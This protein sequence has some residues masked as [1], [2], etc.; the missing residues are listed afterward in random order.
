[1][2][3]RTGPGR[4]KHHTPAS[5]RWTTCCLPQGDSG[6]ELSDFSDAGQIDSC[7]KEALTLLVK[8][9]TVGGNAGKL[10]PASTVTRAEMGQVLYQLILEKV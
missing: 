10:S 3:A 8:T 1:M 6:N 4:E 7:A 5:D 9:G 2:L